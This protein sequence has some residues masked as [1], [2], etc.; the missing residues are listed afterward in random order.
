MED[1]NTEVGVLNCGYSHHCPRREHTPISTSP[2]LS[3]LLFS[4]ADGLF[5]P[6]DVH[7]PNMNPPRQNETKQNCFSIPSHSE[8]MNKSL[9]YLIP[10]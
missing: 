6:W 10:Y 4:S 3:P 2:S 5:L 7:G 8:W 9:G 1:G